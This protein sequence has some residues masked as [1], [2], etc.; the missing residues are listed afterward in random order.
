MTGMRQSSSYKNRKMETGLNMDSILKKD[1]R[2]I[3]G[4]TGAVGSGKSSVLDLMEERF[5]IRIL[6]ADELGHEAY[7]RDTKEYEKIVSHFGNGILTGNREIDRKKLGA[8][9][10]KNPDCLEWLN[11]FIHP[12]VRKRI[13][14]EIALAKK[15]D[16]WKLFFLESAILLENGYEDICNE[17]WYIHVSEEN[18]K[19]RLIKGRG[20]SEEKVEEILKNQMDE[21]YF[22]RKC[23]VVIDNNGKI[24]DT[25]KQITHFLDPN[26]FNVV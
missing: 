17:F 7:R 10:F 22:R 15:Q 16:G 13:V 2:K 26:M 25:L 6:K 20:Y 5:P 19:K 9:A 3:I 23:R 14:N 8:L 4:I 11:H 21:S 1:D 24:E 12:Y 18:R